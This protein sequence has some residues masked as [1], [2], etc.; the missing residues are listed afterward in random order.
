MIGNKNSEIKFIAKKNNYFSAESNS[1]VVK[2][3]DQ[4]SS[5][6]KAAIFIAASWSGFFVMGVELLGGRLLSP[7]FG[8]SIFVWG[9]IITVFMA[10]LSIGYLIGGRIS[11]RILSLKILGALLLMEA[12]FTFPIIVMGDS[13]MEAISLYVDDARYGSLVGSLVMFGAPTVMS[14]MVSPYAVR[15]LIT[16]VHNS[17]GVAGRL[18]FASTIGSALG[19]ILTSFYL[20]LYFEINTII[21]IYISISVGVGVWL[22]T[23]VNPLNYKS[24]KNA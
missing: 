19:T 23:L 4:L 15:L 9:G 21:G 2:P 12:L 8:S 20:V 7:F 16:D 6:N 22:M 17:G 3:N 24:K 18:Y 5:I 10:C 14:G 13:T 11:T 1:K